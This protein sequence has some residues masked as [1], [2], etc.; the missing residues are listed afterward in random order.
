MWFESGNFA[1]GTREG[2]K[3]TDTLFY[4]WLNKGKST[5]FA[6]VCV[7]PAEIVKG[8]REVIQT[9][10]FILNCLMGIWR[11]SL[12][13][14][15]TI[16]FKSVQSSFNF[17]AWHRFEALDNIDKNENNRCSNERSDLF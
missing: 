9:I 8:T 3:K 1:K 14:G 10:Q 11:K 6:C 15:P 12:G 17:A 16:Y 2:G 5:P 13:I 4:I 7:F